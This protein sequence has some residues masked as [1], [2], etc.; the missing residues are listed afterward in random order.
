MRYTRFRTYLLTAFM[1]VFAVAGLANKK[2]KKVLPETVLKAQTVTVVIQGDARE[3]MSDPNANLKVQQEVEK[4]L[5][6]W[7][8]FRLVP[9][10]Q[11]A[12][13]VIA[14]QKG[15]G[16]VAEPT[17]GG[18][19]VDNRPVIVEG[20]D[21]SIRFGGHQ[22]TPPA[23][24][25]YPGP[26]TT[27]PSEGTQIGGSDDRMTVYLG[28]VDYPLD[29]A[30]IWNYAGKDAL[31]APDVKAVEEF[32]KAIAEAEKAAHPPAPKG[33]SGGPGTPQPGNSP[34]PTTPPTD[35]P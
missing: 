23:T 33:G 34:T 35:K 19:P 26:D 16:K 2:E 28:G 30:P 5:M 9:D 4:A 20:T 13:L 3:P 1:V 12:D 7:G 10:V 32:R 21:N 24:T 22:G 11:T 31:K 15:T 14:V 18:G 27:R 6:R 8:R 17:I 25:Q 29:G